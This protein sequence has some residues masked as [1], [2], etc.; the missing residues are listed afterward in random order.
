MTRRK[1]RTQIKTIRA[2]TV[3]LSDDELQELDKLFNN[4]GFMVSCAESTT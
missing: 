2:Y 4:Y 1:L 3:R